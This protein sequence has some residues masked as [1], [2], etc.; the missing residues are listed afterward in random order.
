MNKIY[1]LFPHIEELLKFE[2]FCRKVGFGVEIIRKMF[3]REEVSFKGEIYSH[4]HQRK[5]HTD[6]SVAKVEPD[7]K[8]PQK[9]RLTLMA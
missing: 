5:Y 1:N 3:N 6:H 2:K 9:F 4:E 8:Q 7:P